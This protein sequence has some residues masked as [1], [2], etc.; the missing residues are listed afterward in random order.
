[1]KEDIE[2]Y[3][4]ICQEFQVLTDQYDEAKTEKEEACQ[5]LRAAMQ[6]KINDSYL[7]MPDLDRNGINIIEFDGLYVK[8]TISEKKVTNI[9][10]VNIIKIA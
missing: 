4:K 6:E 3:F 1:M 2:K 7:N 10:P 8:L 5:D 9:Q